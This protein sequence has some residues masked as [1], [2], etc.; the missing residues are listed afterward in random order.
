MYLRG[1]NAVQFIL[2]GCQLPPSVTK[3][4]IHFVLQSTISGWEQNLT[5]CNVDIRAKSGSPFQEKCA[6]PSNERQ[7]NYS[8]L[9]R[10]RPAG[11]EGR[12]INELGPSN[13]RKIFRM[14]I[15]TTY[16]VPPI[17]FFPLDICV[18][19]TRRSEP[20]KRSCQTLLYRIGAHM[21]WPF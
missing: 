1:T 17:F 3:T 16:T 5:C 18:K 11:R 7:L 13:T 20:A 8:F 10:P 21:K 12:A 6:K 19:S 2:R 9:Y 15:C 4:A 14:A